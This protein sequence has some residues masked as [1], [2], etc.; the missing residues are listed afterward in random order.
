[1]NVVLMEL[2]KVCSVVVLLF[3][4]VLILRKVGCVVVLLFILVLILRID[5]YV[6]LYDDVCSING[7]VVKF[8]VDSLFEEYGFNK[9][10]SLKEFSFLMKE[11]KIGFIISE[12]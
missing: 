2:V 1:M 10:M 11:F 3:I 8:F 9:F 12:V 4:L 5:C 6:F 7:L